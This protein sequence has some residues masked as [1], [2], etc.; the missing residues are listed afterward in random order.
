[1]N[2]NYLDFEQPIAELQVRIEELRLVGS[3]NDLNITEEIARLEEKSR[4][5]TKKI[6]ADLSA[7]QVSKMARHPLRPY[8]R[9]YIKSIFT[10][11]DEMH[12]DRHYSDDPAIIGGTARL[13]DQP[14]MVI[15]HQKGRDNVLRCLSLPSSIRL[16]L[17]P[18]LV[19]KKGGRARRLQRIWP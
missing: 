5:L 1:M 11:F 14:V 16:A 7:W 10:D 15:G 19:P 17:T 18:G 2:T 3:D 6:F 8:T 13:D 9:D 4:G 12:G